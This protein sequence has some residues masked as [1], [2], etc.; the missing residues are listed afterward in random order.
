[1][2]EEV[3]PRDNLIS[4][5]MSFSGYE[6]RRKDVLYRFIKDYLGG[7]DLY[8][9]GYAYIY[10]RDCDRNINTFY[11]NQGLHECRE[12]QNNSEPLSELCNLAEELYD[13]KREQLEVNEIHQI[14]LRCSNELRLENYSD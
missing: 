5:T 14:W 4:V 9:G 3:S 1:M 6:I 12:L 10:N 2:P 11:D 8:L 13:E 7:C